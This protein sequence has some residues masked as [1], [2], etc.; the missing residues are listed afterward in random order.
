MAKGSGWLVTLLAGLAVCCGIKLLF[1]LGGFSFLAAVLTGHA[2]WLVAGA[3]V[4]ALATGAWWFR[5][6]RLVRFEHACAGRAR[7]T[8]AAGKPE[9][10]QPDTRT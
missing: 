4:L 10:A 1:L 7:Q 2:W 3:V 6:R 9:A 5:R 8:S